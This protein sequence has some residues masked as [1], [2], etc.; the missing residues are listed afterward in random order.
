MK[1]NFPKVPAPPNNFD[2]DEA[3]AFGEVMTVLACTT[4][5]FPK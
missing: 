5:K 2:N 4:K 1:Y 3:E